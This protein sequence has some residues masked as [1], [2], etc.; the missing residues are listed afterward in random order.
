MQAI[1]AR[2][3]GGPEVLELVE[4][5]DPEPGAGEVLVAVTA[6]GVNRAD[7]L[8]RQGHYPPPPGASPLIGLEVAGHVAA[9]GAGVAGWEV[10]DACAALLA[11][12]G[13]AELV[14]VPAGQVVPPPPGLELVEAAGLVEV[15]A[16][17]VS[18]LEL[19]RLARGE[20]FLVHGG[21]GGIGSFAIQYAAHLGA[22]V[23]TTAGSTAKLDYCRSLG[24]DHAFSYRDDWVAGVRAAA[25]DGVDVV[26]DN[27]GAKYLGDHVDL[28]ATGGRLVVIGLQGGS[29]GTLDL[30]ALL[31]K[32]AGV[33]ATTLRSRPVEEKAEICRRV[34]EQVW[35]LV[36]DGTI[37]PTPQTRFPLAEAAAAHAHLESG[38]NLGKVVLTV[39]DQE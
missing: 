25:P 3:A 4:L 10:G 22:T 27:M 2:E 14:A 32:R 11:G 19:A 13:Y 17:V 5:P 39:G 24:A 1:V 6:A 9:V 26:L 29:R 30:G 28:L 21:A 38:D 12:G 34:V 15:A 16:T 23:V 8:Q 20:V 18:N 7:L 31:A 36:A 37:A 35:P 33:R